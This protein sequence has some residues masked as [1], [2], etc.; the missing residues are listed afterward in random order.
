M[1]KTVN[2]VLIVLGA[3]LILIEVVLGAISGFDFLL[4][5]SCILLGGI[6]GLVSGLPLLGVVA[7]GVLSLVYLLVGRKKIRQKLRRPGVPS[8]TDALIGKT[9][10]VTETITSD[11]AGRVKLEGEEWRA[12]LE[13][14]LR[15]ALAAGGSVRIVRVE[16]VAVYVE[17]IEG[18][19]TQG[20]R[21]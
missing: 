7:A 6:L 17:P 20:G 13:N 2:I 21:P 12:V 4:I 19:P 9:A 10:R 14:P 18:V 16:G 15:G 3:V 1:L 5:G 8:N 11:R